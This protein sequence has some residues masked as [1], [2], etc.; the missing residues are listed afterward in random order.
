MFVKFV[1]HILVTIS[2][3]FTYGSKYVFFSTI[4]KIPDKKS[5]IE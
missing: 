3:F 4:K 5:T 2:R 1:D